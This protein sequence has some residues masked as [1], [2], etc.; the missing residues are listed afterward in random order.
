MILPTSSLVSTSSTTSSLVSTT[1][2]HYEKIVFDFNSTMTQ[3]IQFIPENETYEIKLQ[4]IKSQLIK[5]E[6]TRKFLKIPQNRAYM[7]EIVEISERLPRLPQIEQ[8]KLKIP[9]FEE[10]EE[11][12][13]DTQEIKKY[14]RKMN[15]KFI[16]F[17]CNH[18][19]SDE[20]CD[21]VYTN[22]AQ[23]IESEEYKEIDKF[24]YDLAVC[25]DN[26]RARD[27]IK[28]EWKGWKDGI[29]LPTPDQIKHIMDVIIQLT[30]KITKFN[31]QMNPECSHCKAIVKLYDYTL[32]TIDRMRRE[33]D[34]A[35]KK[36]EQL[37]D[38]I[39]NGVSDS[40]VPSIAEFINERFEGTD[41][42]KLSEIK[43]SYNRLYNIT[44]T[45]TQLTEEVNKMGT[46]RV[47][48]CKGIR[49]VNKL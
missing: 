22:S 34:E 15:P 4:T 35:R 46:H 31:A 14:I 2:T 28:C 43:D 11:L 7:R 38:E 9:E 26:I 6:F 16:G 33:E 40:K 37:K 24:F 27:K 19:V 25:I 21:C 42:F 23:I 39:E 47:S 17:Y 32:R 29:N 36:R 18:K 44:K 48:N 41:R 20:K 12:P 8:Q 10:I 1:S 13:T 45:L 5:R 3:T 49:W 30:T